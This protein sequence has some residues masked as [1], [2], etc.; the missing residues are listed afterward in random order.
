MSERIR[1]LE[2]GLAIL[3][4]SNTRDPHPLLRPDLLTIKSGLELHSAVQQR[5]GAPLSEL[6]EDED[7]E[8]I[9]AFGTLAVRDDGAA[10]YYGRSAGSE[11]C[12]GPLTPGVPVTYVGR[13]ESAYGEYY[14]PHVHRDHAVPSYKRPNVMHSVYRACGCR[15]T[16]Y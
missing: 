8:Q 4:S 7:G 14:G 5:S 9:D 1:Q 15:Y 6:N 12:D 11:V 3:Q 10:T 16:A 2:D 13:S